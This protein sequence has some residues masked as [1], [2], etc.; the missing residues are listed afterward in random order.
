M[1]GRATFLPREQILRN[2]RL[3]WSRLPC[4]YI[5]V[6]CIIVCATIVFALHDSQTIRGLPKDGALVKSSRILSIWRSTAERDG[7][8]DSSPRENYINR[9]LRPILRNPIGILDDG[10]R[11]SVKDSHSRHL[12]IHKLQFAAHLRCLLSLFSSLPSPLRR[13]A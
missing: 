2:G 12:V 1:L 8:R 5:C 6:S 13:R 10:R 3:R 4:L 7:Q 11:E 9:A